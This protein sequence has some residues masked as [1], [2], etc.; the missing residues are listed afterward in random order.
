MQV[1]S[2]LDFLV[3]ISHHIYRTSAKILQDINWTGRYSLLNYR[4]LGLIRGKK[5]L[6]FVRG[7]SKKIWACPSG[8]GRANTPNLRTLVLDCATSPRSDQFFSNIRKKGSLW[9]FRYY[10]SRSFSF[11][12]FLKS[13]NKIRQS[14]FT[15]HPQF[16]T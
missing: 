7:L 9:A 12:A 1:V 2:F 3:L 6:N 16:F 13:R 4:M 11:S 15:L 8:S 5:D 14:I 10:P